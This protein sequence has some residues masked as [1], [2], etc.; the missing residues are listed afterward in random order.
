M[1]P[2]GR[3]AEFPELHANAPMRLRGEHIR[4]GAW[5]VVDG[6]RVFHVVDAPPRAESG[7]LIGSGG[8]FDGRG[9]WRVGLNNASVTWNGEADFTIDEPSPQRW[10]V[11]LWHPVSIRK[12]V[13]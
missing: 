12:D 6:R 8:I 4:P 5:L 11:Q 7:N 13:E 10:R 9:G 3:P 1:F 2:G